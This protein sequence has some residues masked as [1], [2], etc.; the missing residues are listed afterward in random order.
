M[1]CI[2]IKMQASIV[3]HGCDRLCIRLYELDM[4]VYRLCR[5]SIDCIQV[6]TC[7]LLLAIGA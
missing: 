4:I 6:F 5:L 3:V 1:H 2:A 7:G